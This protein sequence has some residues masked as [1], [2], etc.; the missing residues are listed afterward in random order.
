MDSPLEVT[1]EDTKVA[2][3]YKSDQELKKARFIFS[4][5]N[6]PWISA[7]AVAF[8]RFALAIRL[9]IIGIIRRTVFQHFCGGESITAAE[10]TILHLA[11]Y[12]V[13]TILDY[14]VEGED[15][16]ED[17]DRTTDEILRTFQKA[18]G[19][20]QIPFCVFK[21]TGIADARLLEKVQSGKPV[22]DEEIQALERVK[23]RVDRIC[24]KAYEYDV[25]VLIDAE[26]SWIQDTIN[27]LSFEMMERYNKENPIV[28]ITLQM[29]LIDA[30]KRLKDI[31]HMA[32][33]HQLYLGVKLVRGAYMEKERER[34]AEL[35]LR[36]PIH[37]TREATDDAFNKALAFCLDHKQRI[38]VMCGSHNEYSNYYLTV[39]MAKHG[40]RPNDERVWFAQLYGMS[41]NISFNLARMGY[42]VAKYVP[43]GPVRSVMPYLFRRAEEN[44]SVY[45]QSSREL[46]LIRNELRRRRGV[47]T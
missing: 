9:P 12:G 19:R 26:E 32:T 47:A 37:P 15:R 24:A 16:E 40:M 43:Y 6:H 45:G 39:L 20:K 27:M 38:S 36:S 28:F 23:H 30:A 33:M 29:Y 21:M 42:N 17:F 10:S 25:P 8:V 3:A 22:S 5:V 2:F 46:T 11:N 18:R 4:L 41:D 34:A 35:G 1:F 14:A 13:N 7:I 31:Y 44:T